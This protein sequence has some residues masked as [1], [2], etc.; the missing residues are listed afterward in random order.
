MRFKP[1]LAAKTGETIS[2]SRR[3]FLPDGTADLSET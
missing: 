3:L 2:T 1:V